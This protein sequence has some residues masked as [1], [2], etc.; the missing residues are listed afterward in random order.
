MNPYI[1]DIC[2]AAECSKDVI[3]NTKNLR[4]YAARLKRRELPVPDWRMP[5]FPEADDETFI[6]FLGVGNAINFC[7]TDMDTKR[8]YATEWDGKEWQGAFGMWAALKRALG[9][10]AP[11]LNPY[12]LALLDGEDAEEI[13]SGEPPLPLFQERID[14]LHSAGTS[15]CRNFNE[16]YAD[17]FRRCNYRAFNNG[18]GIVEQLVRYDPAYRDSTFYRPVR[19]NLHFHKRA[20]LFVVMYQGRALSSNETL[21][22]IEDAYDLTPPADYEVPRA[23]RYLGILEYSDELAE[24]VDSQT[25]IPASSRWEFEIRTQTVAAMRA[26]C[27]RSGKPIAA[28]DYMVW[29][30]GREGNKPHHL[31]KTTA[32]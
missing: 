20:N 8:K 6:Q 4:G 30:A 18:E 3:I 16:I 23:L 27:E 24:T 11:V 26:L 5:V 7:F 19:R 21:P 14:C 15:L 9:E 32:Y 28:L 13:F 25:E 22:L 29:L 10:G 2:E 1:D 31:T 17:L 12:F